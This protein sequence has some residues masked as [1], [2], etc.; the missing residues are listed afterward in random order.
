MAG[1]VAEQSPEAGSQ[2]EP[3]SRV[4]LLVFAPNQIPLPNVVGQTVDDATAALENLSLVVTTEEVDR[5]GATAGNVV[6]QSPTSGTKVDPGST[7]KLSVAMARTEAPAPDVVGATQ[8][9]AVSQLE[10]AGFAVAVEEAY[11]AQV[12]KGI[13]ISQRPAAGVTA[14]IGEVVTIVVSL[15]PSPEV[16]VPNVVGL[17]EAEAAKQLNSLGLEPVPS[18]AYSSSVPAGSVISQ[19][20]AAGTIALQ[21]TFVTIVVSQGPEPASTA[22]VPNVMGTSESEAT[23]LLQAAGYQVATT[24]VYSDTIAIGTVGW[25]SPAAGSITEPGS[26]VAIIVSGGP[27]PA[28]YTTVPDVRSMSLEDATQALE[29]AGL[30]VESYEVATSLAPAGQVAAQLPAAGQS[31]A[32]GST[33]IIII[34]LGELAVTPY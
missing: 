32:P 10:A 16:A 30:V 33:V 19:N 17:S 27:R 26:T 3:E 1:T 23:S 24:R 9:A 31:V 11:D 13:V 34:S 12:A 14:A 5:V 7:V 15:G 22:T 28:E 20:P 6:A 2:V 4:D 21:G 25:Q 8:Q 18:R 29:D